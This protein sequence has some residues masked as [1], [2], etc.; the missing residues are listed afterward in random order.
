MAR[1]AKQAKRNGA[2]AARIDAML[3]L[4]VRDIWYPVMPSWAVSTAPV[5]ITRL[6]ERLVAWRD[7]TGTVRL[8]ED[9][10]PHRGSRLSLGWNRGDRLACWYHGLQVGTDGTVLRVP[11]V[12]SCVLEGT[13]TLRTYE[14]R[15][16]ASAI[17]AYFGAKP[18]TK[19]P[20]LVLPEQLTAPQY[21]NFLS[22]AHWRCSYRYVMDNNVD[23]VHGIYLH[24]YSHSMTEGTDEAKMHV[25]PT[26]TGFVFEKLNQRD[27]NLDWSE[28]GDT[29][30]HWIRA[31][32]PYQKYAGPGGVFWI[33]G[34]WVP[35][36]ANNCVVFFW[37]VRKVEGWM[38]ASW[39]FLYKMRL[40]GLHW[41]VLEQDRAMLEN[42][43]RDAR[44]H[45]FLYEHDV[46]LARMRRHLERKAAAQL[47]GSRSK[48][49][50][51]AAR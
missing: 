15:E 18:G 5:G 27:V 29:N 41:D 31:I 1:R 30:L 22:A 35:V 49:A 4:G 2:D 24:R 16:A 38:R 48:K 33:I 37:R 51:P 34:S 28:F 14:T 3:D 50:R 39:R 10:C 8:L 32:T 20:P 40:E 9:R 13:R 44:Q 17:F 25:R 23:P 46:G 11:A 45:E 42:F 36:D 12:P 21:D 6:G 26:K 43:P 7:R 47:A 19:A